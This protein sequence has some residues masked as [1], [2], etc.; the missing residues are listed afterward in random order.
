MPTNLKRIGIL[1]PKPQ[2]LMGA[3]ALNGIEGGIEE[4]GPHGSGGGPPEGASAT[5]AKRMVQAVQQ[6]VAMLQIQQVGALRAVRCA[7]TSPPCA[8][9]RKPSARLG[10]VAQ[11]TQVGT[12]W[13][14]AANCT[15]PCIGPFSL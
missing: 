13:Y 2:D 10:S 9:G 1:H 11:V 4:E 5:A 7:S 12:S 3:K 14:R 15:A 8:G 6:F